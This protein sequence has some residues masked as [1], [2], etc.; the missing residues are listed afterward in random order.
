MAADTLVIGVPM[1]N[2]A[3]PSVLKA[4]I[5]HICRVGRTFSYSENGPTGLA[6]GK[7]AVL[8][9]SRGGVYTD[10]PAQAMD[11]QTAYL[12]SV[13]NFIGITDVEL[14]IAEGMSMGEENARQAVAHAKQ[15]ISAVV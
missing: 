2:F 8:I 14:V 4:W 13:L 7:R 15:K 9:L 11:F 10:G 6:T 3:L 1:Y 12:R 5:D